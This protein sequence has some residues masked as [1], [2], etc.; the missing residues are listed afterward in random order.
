MPLA[1]FSNLDFDQVKTT[2]Q[3]YL[4]SNS[5]F[6]DYDF[7]GSNLSTLLDVL[8]YNTYITSYNANMITNEVFIDTATLRENIVSLARNIGYVPR[9]RQAARATVSFFV[10]T[11]G[12]NPAPATLTLK[13]G[14][15]AASSSAFG[16]QSFVFSILSDITVPV[17]NGIAEFNDVEVFEGTLLTQTFTYSSRI[18]NQ[19]FILPNIGVDTDLITVSVRPN[20]ASTTETKYSV[21]NSLF[22]VKSDSKVYYLQEIEDERY[23]IFF[24]DGIFGKELEDG[25]F[26]TI[27]YITSSGD[28]A[29]GLSSFNFAG[30]IEYTR[31]ASTYTISAGIS[32]MT[33]GLSASGGETI[34]SV[35]S[36]RKFAPRIYSSQ[37]RAVTSNDYESLIPAR[38]Y[39]ETESISVFGG[40]DLIPPQFGKVFI[41]IKPR[42]GDFL[43][44][45]IKEKI[46]LK[47]KKYSV[48]GI[49]PEI[50]DL[51][52]L[53][54][55][56]NTKI[57]Y[58]TN[59]AP[60]AAYVS[61]L[62]QNNA[63]KYAE[64]S[65]MNKYGARFKY[66]KFLNII[67]QSNESITSNITTVYIRRDIRAVL[68]AFAEYQIGFGNAF[69]IKSMSGYNIKSSAFRIAGVMDDVY[70]SDLPNTNRLNGSL[71]LFTLPS[72]ESQSPTIIRRNVGNIDYTSGVITINP[73]N[74]QSGMIKD[75]QTIIEISACPL[76]NDVIGLQD[77]Y[78]QL[79]IS[80]SLFETVVDEIASGLDPSGSNYITSSSYANGILVR[81]GGRNSDITT[82]NT[83]SVPST[84]GSSATT[85]SSFSGST[86]SAGS[87]Y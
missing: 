7:E 32:L 31:N 40:E 19:K 38:I 87:S 36:V 45:L 83:S 71:F 26:I 13:K 23:Q 80:N 51:K 68:N 54:L 22:D 37:N 73:I 64:S 17:F 57:Y 20:E 81:A 82:T 59:L 30:R 34:E 50:L 84:S 58:N 72:I 1:N 85:P 6:T 3:E 11:S 15:V 2:L 52:Y 69:H 67:D 42:T 75:G 8:A 78:L 18:P 12:I 53:Y 16:G 61:T 70:I 47:L 60:D 44:S 41:S 56:I 49:V 74:V 43:P 77:L 33:T 62:V 9:P 28:S 27:N 48:A 55:E 24:G 21:Q 63:E 76:S 5:N 86:S 4:K 14:P 66:S 25:N 79:D 39:P 65:D 46:K 10:N 29:N 35:E